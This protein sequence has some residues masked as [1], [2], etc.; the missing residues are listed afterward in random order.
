MNAFVERLG[1]VLVH[2]LRQFALA[3][4]LAGVTV[5]ALRRR[6]AALRYV[7]LVAPMAVSV[8]APLAT[9]MCSPNDERDDLASRATPAPDEMWTSRT[10]RG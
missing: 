2:S 8:V 1:W 9:W 10:V 3:A 6:S 7:V 5:R 4:L